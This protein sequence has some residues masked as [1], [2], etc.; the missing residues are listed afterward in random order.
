MAIVGSPIN[1]PD[2]RKVM[3]SR[4]A[5]VTLG[6]NASAQVVFS[7]KSERVTTLGIHA[8]CDVSGPIR[9]YAGWFY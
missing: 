8:G 2:V 3:L 6:C 9:Q 5:G 7:T 1:L 4:V